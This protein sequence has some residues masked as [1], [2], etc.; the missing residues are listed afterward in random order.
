ME[1]LGASIADDREM[2]P[3]SIATVRGN[4]ASLGPPAAM[5][6]K[7]AASLKQTTVY[8]VGSIRAFANGLHYDKQKITLA[9]W[10]CPST[11]LCLH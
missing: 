6:A 2:V 11:P 10:I 9:E 1:A 5:R 4:D 7:Q 3:T 8:F